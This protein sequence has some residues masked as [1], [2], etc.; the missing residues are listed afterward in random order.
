M[1]VEFSPQH[2]DYLFEPFQ[3][4]LLVRQME[5]FELYGLLCE[6]L[7]AATAFPD[8]VKATGS[9]SSPELERANR[10]AALAQKEIERGFS[11]LTSQGIIVLWGALE[12]LTKDFLIRWLDLFPNLW[13]IEEIASLKIRIGEYESLCRAD[14]SRYVIGELE[15]SISSHLKP[16]VGRFES[17]LEKLALSGGVDER[18][19]KDLLE[20][21][22]IRNILVHN[23]GHVDSRF[24]AFCPWSEATLGDVI[25]PTDKDYRR[26]SAS[27]L[28]YAAAIMDRAES[29][30]R[31]NSSFKPMP[32]PGTA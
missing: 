4:L 31:S 14:R 13:L 16:G 29:C 17:T 22:A 15:R 24:L 26:F 21:W 12:T 28:R 9:S 3:R 32:L 18:I 30:I 1:S 20:L 27:V 23:A 25:H 2:K 8:L 5:Y 7:H 6:A 11:S 19:R 10:N